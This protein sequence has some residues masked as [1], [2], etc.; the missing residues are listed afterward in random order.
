MDSWCFSLAELNFTDL[1]DAVLIASPDVRFAAV[2]QTSADLE[3]LRRNQRSDATEG[4]ALQACGRV[5]FGKGAQVQGGDQ[6]TMHHQPRITFGLC[7]IRPVIV[8]SMAIEGDCGIT[9]QQG[10]GRLDPFLPLAFR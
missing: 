8:N 9:E 1:R 6:W 4:E 5:R 7:H 2:D 10:G 3:R